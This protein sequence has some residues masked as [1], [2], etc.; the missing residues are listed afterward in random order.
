[1][2]LKGTLY[3]CATPIGNLG[4]ITL[5]VLETLRAVDFIAC[6]DTR[7]TGKL[8]SKFDIKKPLI[9]YFEHNKKSHGEVIISRLLE[10]K[11]VALVSDAGMPIISDPGDS[12]VES[13]IEN[14][15]PYTVLPGPCALVTALALSGM[16]A[17]RFC[18][19]GFLSVSTKSRK[20]HL[21]SLKNERRTMIFYEAPHKLMR[22][23]EDFLKAFGNR[24]IVICRELTKKFEEVIR[25]DIKSCIEHFTEKAPK[26]EFVVLLSGAAEETTDEAP[27]WQ[28]LT[29]EEHVFHYEQSGLSRTDAMK[30][31]A[32]D[33]G[34]SKR[35]IYSALIK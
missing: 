20:E 19:E 33:R 4:D 12:L 10:G 34:I 14:D 8:L 23:L 17:K 15:I 28:E 21:A 3:L 5:R 35:D 1:M 18:F 24:D 6:E 2:S 27:F 31:A 9:S 26:G 16:P 22:T 32:K 29:P 13:C 11:S 7:E 30:A 25:G